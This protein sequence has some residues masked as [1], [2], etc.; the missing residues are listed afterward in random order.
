MMNEFSHQSEIL[1]WEKS[2]IVKQP[3]SWWWISV[4][5][6]TFT[7]LGSNTSTMLIFQKSTIF[8]YIIMTDFFPSLYQYVSMTYGHFACSVCIEYCFYSP[9]SNSNL[10]THNSCQESEPMLIWSWL[11]FNEKGWFNPLHVLLFESVC[12][13]NEIEYQ[14]GQE[15]NQYKLNMTQ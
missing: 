13:K 2:I 9:K 4:Y 12:I 1:R 11:W 14:K 5:K 15:M 3:S 6:L 7:A 8:N 10:S